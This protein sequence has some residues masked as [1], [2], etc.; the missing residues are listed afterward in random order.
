MIPVKRRAP[1]AQH[2]QRLFNLNNWTIKDLAK[3]AHV[4]EEH[5][6]Y[7]LNFAREFEQVWYLQQFVEKRMSEKF[8]I[9]IESDSEDVLRTLQES[10]LTLIPASKAKAVRQTRVNRQSP[11]KK[12]PEVERYPEIRELFPAEG[13][14]QNNTIYTALT[15]NRITNKAELCA[16]GSMANLRK[17]P[18][19]GSTLVDVIVEVMLSKGLQF[20]TA[21]EKVEVASTIEKN[22]APEKETVKLTEIPSSDGINSFEELVTA[23]A[24]LWEQSEEDSYDDLSANYENSKDGFD[25]ILAYESPATEETLSDLYELVGVSDAQTL[26]RVEHGRPIE[27]ATEGEIKDMIEQA[28]EEEDYFA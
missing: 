21:K 17:V 6:W 22:E 8:R 9:I 27:S 10:G 24:A 20:T 12:E 11:R 15:K 2:L 18:R 23:H 7:L 1:A 14:R 3:I 28:G 4:T 5:V 25:E 26:Y 16:V 19:L 13:G